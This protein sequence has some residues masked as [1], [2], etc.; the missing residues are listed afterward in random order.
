MGCKSRNKYADAKALF[1]I[2][3]F[4]SG[5]ILCFVYKQHLIVPFELRQGFQQGFLLDSNGLID[6]LVYY[7]Q[8]VVYDMLH[9]VCCLPPESWVIA[10]WQISTS[11]S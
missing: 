1:V 11:F 3:T 10:R 5:L 2:V 7:I 4:V 8:Y 6:H 9:Y